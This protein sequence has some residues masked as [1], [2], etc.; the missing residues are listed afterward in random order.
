MTKKK[1]KGWLL[2]AMMG[3]IMVLALSCQKK[4]G[5]W[6]REWEEAF[7]EWQPSDRIMDVLGVK[8]GMVIG[9]I[10]AGN[11]R[12]A[13]KMA[14]RVGK[15]GK[16]YANDIDEKALN[17]M[18]SRVQRENIANMNVIKGEVADPRFPPGELDLVYIVNT[19]EHLE[20]PVEILKNLSPAL[21]PEGILAIIVTDPDKV[22]YAPNHTVTQE[23]VF[24]DV[25]QADTFEPL[26]TETFLTQDNIYIFR[27]K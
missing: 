16:V 23:E 10:G 13:V 7:E 6:S 25:A 18:Q 5:H 2:L 14:R 21:K 1:R 26:R 3:L 12:L 27:L 8:P 22:D 11:G 15:N 9:E 20:Q 24:N 17:F 4:D 19:Y